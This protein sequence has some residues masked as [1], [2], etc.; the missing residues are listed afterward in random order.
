MGAGNEPDELVALPKAL[1]AAT[2][3]HRYENDV[4]DW[5]EKWLRV[6]DHNQQRQRPQE[7]RSLRSTQSSSL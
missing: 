6:V 2:I 3:D 1:R 5:A 7:R 4:P